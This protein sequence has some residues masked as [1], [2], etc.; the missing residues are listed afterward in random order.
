MTD[1]LV[2]Q[3]EPGLPAYRLVG[4][5]AAIRQHPGVKSV[6]DIHFLTQETLDLM[7]MRPEPAPVK[8]KRRSKAA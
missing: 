2:V 4:L 3:I 8:K 5:F 7:L 6:A 1:M